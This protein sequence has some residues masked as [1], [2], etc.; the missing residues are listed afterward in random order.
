MTQSKLS[1]SNLK[2]ANLNLACNQMQ[3]RNRRLRD[4]LSVLWRSDCLSHTLEKHEEWGMKVYTWLLEELFHSDNQTYLRSFQQQI[5]EILS[6]PWL[7]PRSRKT[8]MGW[9]CRVQHSQFCCYTVSFFL[10]HV[11]WIHQVAPVVGKVIVHYQW[12]WG[13]GALVGNYCLWCHQ[14]VS[15]AHLY[16]VAF[17]W[18]RC[19][20]GELLCKRLGMQHVLVHVLCKFYYFLC[21]VGNFLTNIFRFKVL[22]TN[23][24]T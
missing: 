15:D 3:L 19:T 22:T 12:Q 5:Y 8:L 9:M 21:P 6:T 13:R 20:Y 23:N 14:V 17:S 11:L 4:S 18:S 16:T 10:F 1:L 7:F 24:S 2:S